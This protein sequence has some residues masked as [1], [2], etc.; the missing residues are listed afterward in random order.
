MTVAVIMNIKPDFAVYDENPKFAYFDSA[1][2]TL[3]PKSSVLTTAHFLDSIVSS[4]R[5]G[6]HKLAVQGNT[7][8]EDTRQSLSKFLETDSASISFQQSIP[9]AV[10]SFVYGYAWKENNKD[11]II[12]AQSEEN[13][14][15]IAALR[16]AEVLGL[17]TEIM[18]IETDGTISPS[19]LDSLIDDKTGIVAIGHVVPAIGVEN[20]IAEIAEVAHSHNALLLTDATR[21]VGLRKESPVS[22]GSDI[23]LFSANIGLMGPPGLTVQWINPFIDR[24][25]TPGILGSFSVSNVHEK[26]YE[27]AFQPDKY[28]SSFINTPAIAGLDTSLKY[29]THLRSNGMIRYLASLSNYMKKKLNEIDGLVLY[30]NI[31]DKTTIFGFN[32]GESSEIGCHDVAL[33]LNESNIAVR[34]GYICSHSLMES[35]VHEGLIQASI[36]AYNSNE[37]IDNLVVTLDTIVEQLL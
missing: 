16:A 23:L 5:R 13:S 28:E 36:H 22:L 4:A 26:T 1:S 29:M 30:G 18:P 8:V 14:V 20:P 33:F 15:Y 9:A 37:D 11:R 2:T 6:A 31:T 25:H 12:I 34:S 24:K 3:V 27:M 17:R 19:L 21:S 35:I 32:L 10:A 7:I